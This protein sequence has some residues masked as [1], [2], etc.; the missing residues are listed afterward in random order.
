MPKL[1]LMEIADGCD[2]CTKQKQKRKNHAI[3]YH[4]LLLSLHLFMI[5]VSRSRQP[6]LSSTRMP[7]LSS[8][9]SG[10][11]RWCGTCGQKAAPR[12]QLRPLWSC[13]TT[14]CVFSRHPLAGCSLSLKMGRERKGGGEREREGIS[15]FLKKSAARGVVQVQVDVI[16]TLTEKIELFNLDL[17]SLLLPL[18]A[19]LLDSKTER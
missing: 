14:L 11:C 12:A 17:F 6:C 1:S 4:R 3:L 9:W 10:H 13:P 19:G 18:L 15:V 5:Y 8:S 16:S 7:L 2:W